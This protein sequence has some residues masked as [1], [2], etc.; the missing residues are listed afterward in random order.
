MDSSIDW[1]LYYKDHNLQKTGMIVPVVLLV[2]VFACVAFLNYMLT[3]GISSSKSADPLIS[4]QCKLSTT[5]K[6]KLKDM[7]KGYPSY[8]VKPDAE[9]TYCIDKSDYQFEVRIL[10][11]L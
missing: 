11:K 6:C 10:K 4:N 7:E 3:P 1:L 9:G 8:L 2:S 5:E